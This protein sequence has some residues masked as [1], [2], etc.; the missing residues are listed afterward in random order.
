M[1][2]EKDCQTPFSSE[3][4]KYIARKLLTAPWNHSRIISFRIHNRLFGVWFCFSNFFLFFCS[5]RAIFPICVLL[6]SPRFKKKKY[7]WNHCD[8]QG[9]AKKSEP[10]ALPIPNLQGPSVWKPPA[11]GIISRRLWLGC[12]GKRLLINRWAPTGTDKVMGGFDLEWILTL[13]EIVTF[14]IC[15]I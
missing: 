5:S 3:I 10:A 12:A 9:G 11:S 6:Q 1:D 8:S 15:Y 13:I 4:P 2:N 14:H 7:K